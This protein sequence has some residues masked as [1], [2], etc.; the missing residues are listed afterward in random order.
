MNWPVRLTRLA[1]LVSLALGTLVLL[2]WYLHEPALIQVNPAFVPMQYNTALGFAL[3]GLALLGLAWSWT[4]PAAVTGLAVLLVGL[5]TLIEY[6]FGLDLHIDQLFM[7]HYIDLETSHPGRMAPNTA[8]CFSLTGL[9]ALISALR[10]RHPQTPAWTATLGAIIIGLGIVALAG[11]II[12]VESA[13]GWGHLTRMAIHT[14]AGFIVLGFGFTALAW[15]WGR[16]LHPEE[17]LPRWLPAVIGITGFTV[18]FAMWQA[19]VAQEQRLINEMGAHAASYADEGLLVFGVLLTLALAIKA[20]A[21]ARAGLRARAAGGAWAPYVVIALGALLA[22][23]LYSLLKTS[24]EGSVRLRFESE[25]RNHGEA[26]ERGIESYI[27]TLYHIRAGFDASSFVDRSEFRVLTERDLQRLPGIMALEWVPLVPGHEREAMEAIAREELSADFV[28]GDKPSLEGMAAAAQR[29]RYFPIYYVEPLQPNLPVLGFDLAGSPGKPATLMKAARTNAPVVSS[30]L[31]LLQSDEGAYAVFI[32]LPVYKRAMPLATSAEREAALRGFALMVTEVGPMIEKILDRYTSPAGLTMIFEDAESTD[33]RG[34]MY[35]HSSRLRAPGEED[36]ETEIG[37]NGF[38]TTATLMFADRQWNMTA[39][40]ANPTLY[41]RWS[42]DNV[43]LPLGVFLLAL[44][45]AFYLRRSAQREQERARILAYQTALLDSIPNPIFVNGIDTLL[46]TCNK[47]YEQAFSIRREDFIG[48]STGDLEHLPEDIR[49]TAPDEELELIRQGGLSRR[50]TA[51]QYGDGRTHD[52]M[53]W[54]TAFDLADG[55]PGGMIG[56]FIDISERKQAEREILNARKAAEA[57]NQAKSNFLANMSHELRTPMNAIL[58]YSEML[59]EEAE[60]VGQD[61]FIPDLRKI[62]QAGTHLL[63]LIND[64]LDLSKIESGR[65]ETFAE[66]VDVSSLIDQ[67]AVTA[68]PLMNQNNNRFKIERGAQLGRVYQ[69]PT[70]LRQSLLNLVSNA[71]K[72]THDGHITLQATRQTR[73]DGDWLIFAVKDT[74]IGI[75]ADK[76]E[77]VFDEFS[78]ADNSTTRD[79]GGTG[80]GLTISR[81]FCQMLGGDLTVTSQ[82]GVGSTFTIRLPAVLPGAEVAQEE[83]T[84]PGVENIPASGD[85]NE[86]RGDST[87]LVI[88]DDAEACE[89]IRRFLEKDG[90]NVVIALSGEDGLRLAHQLQPAAITLD[91]MMP[92]M[93]GWSVLRALKVDPVLQAVPVVMLTMVDDKSKGYALG[94]TDYLTKPIDRNLLHT[95]LERFHT[96]NE[97]CSVLLVEDE[98]ATREMMARTLEKADWQ[99]IEAGNGREALDRLAQQKP[100]LILLD[101]MMP[102]MDGFDFLLEMR[103]RPEWQD[104]PVIVLTA[105]DL[106]EEDRRLL[107]GR[108]EQIVEKGACAHDQVVNLIHRVVDHHAASTGTA[109]S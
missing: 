29:E 57:S 70:K 79:Y 59:M 77:H 23:S 98:Q 7:R 84:Q 13:Y 89:I 37:K 52:V 100:R 44:G 5:L 108:V 28:F 9:A 95:A 35:R 40:A 3:G 31:H 96:P 101:L 34:F 38:R 45:L 72:F 69:D 53:Y 62:N 102:V 49:Q 66:D 80:L 90:F 64:V 105:K 17:R 4:R 94:A 12:G 19:L 36:T 14:A 82:P 92:D 2:G 99:V 27:E 46:T 10:H 15:A 30:R 56:L 8:L 41:P 67:V 18:T 88:D 48:K 33:G 107:S 91:V 86:A 42:L 78:Q 103:A 32:A 25:V 26:I 21:V 87:I 11:Y 104:I 93:D 58:G 85:V 55:E 60:E 61:A 47:A 24:F 83:P 106:T 50:E 75:A 16:R 63:S 39:Y 54:R 68:Q 71:A 97:P 20:R 22:F 74:G 81:R 65:M 6:L 73:A 109:C 1:G 76:L 43:W 51:L